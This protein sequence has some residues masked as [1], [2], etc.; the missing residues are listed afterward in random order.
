M[1]LG[2]SNSPA[3]FVPYRL[4]RE[5]IRI[6]SSLIYDHP[7]DFACAIDLVADKILQPSKIVTETVPFDSIGRALEIASTGKSGKVHSVFS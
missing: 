2:L 3:S 1:L 4:V 5:G 7:E 6:E